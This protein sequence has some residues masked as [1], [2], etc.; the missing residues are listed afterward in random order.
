MTKP[1]AMIAMGQNRA[2]EARADQMANLLEASRNSAV[3]VVELT[4][5]VGDLTE[6]VAVLESSR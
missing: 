4:E 1:N 6:R 5:L 2:A 3:R